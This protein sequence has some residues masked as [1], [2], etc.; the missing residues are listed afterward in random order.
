LHWSKTIVRHD[1]DVT[2][3]D[4]EGAIR[5]RVPMDLADDTT[6]RLLLHRALTGLVQAKDRPI[7]IDRLVKRLAASTGNAY[8]TRTM[9]P[10]AAARW[11]RARSDRAKLARWPV[12]QLRR[13]VDA[14]LRDRE[15]RTARN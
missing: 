6:W 4:R 15:L 10:G 14:V 1:G 12:R 5:F 3:S 2:T 11:R 7:R 8:S 9:R 13:M